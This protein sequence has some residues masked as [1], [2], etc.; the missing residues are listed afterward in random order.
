ML[1]NGSTGSRVVAIMGSKHRKGSKERYLLGQN[2]AYKFWGYAPFSSHKTILKQ[3]LNGENG[4]FDTDLPLVGLFC[5]VG[6]V[7]SVSEV[8]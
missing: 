6:L 5:Y 4:M 7:S 2:T 1:A 3:Q 8:F